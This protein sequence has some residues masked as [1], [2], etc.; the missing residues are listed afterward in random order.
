MQDSQGAC[1]LTWPPN[2]GSRQWVPETAAAA[3][4]PR[5]GPPELST[6]VALAAC[7]DQCG[8]RTAMMPGRLSEPAD[9]WLTPW[10]GGVPPA[11]MDITEPAGCDPAQFSVPEAAHRDPAITG[12]PATEP[13]PILLTRIVCNNSQ[14]TRCTVFR[15]GLAYACVQL[16]KC[17]EPHPLTLSW[18]GAATTTCSVSTRPKPS[19]YT[20]PPGDILVVLSSC[21]RLCFG[22]VDGTAA[23][24]NTG[25]VGCWVY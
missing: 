4:F 16:E 15:C 7:G 14:C 6:W 19:A 2:V 1:A 18:L 22:G 9:L 10:P 25:M 5:R 20:P 8:F 13:M 23:A 3:I 24:M 21:C 17:G 11:R 12:R